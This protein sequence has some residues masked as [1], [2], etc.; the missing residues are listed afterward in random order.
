MFSCASTDA[1]ATCIITKKWLVTEIGGR[2]GKDGH[3]LIRVDKNS[4][5]V[6]HARGYRGINW[7]QRSRL[8]SRY[9]GLVRFWSSASDYAAVSSLLLKK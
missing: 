3:E 7:Q 9:I 8:A 4:R 2:L 5:H 6:T 1:I